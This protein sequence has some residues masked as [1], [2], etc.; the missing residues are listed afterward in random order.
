[1]S[2]ERQDPPERG[3]TGRAAGL[4][5]SLE[6]E[7]MQVLWEAGPATVREVLAHLN[8]RRAPTGQLA[9]T[10]VMTV[11]SRLHDKGLAD[12][13]RWGRGYRY[14]PR[15]SEAGLVRHLGRQEVND[16]IARFGPVALAQFAAALEEA[17]PDLLRRAARLA[18]ID[19]ADREGP[20]DDR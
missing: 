6:Y 13:R 19:A 8:D 11:L 5:G 10:T 7:V 18:G 17:D 14:T 2:S 9:Y 4:L 12:R 3:G 1:M 15:F 20:H 16:L